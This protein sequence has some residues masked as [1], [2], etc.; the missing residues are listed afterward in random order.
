MSGEV[1][2]GHRRVGPRAL[3]ADLGLIVP[4]IVEEGRMSLTRTAKMKLSAPNRFFIGGSWTKPSSSAE[5]DVI[6]AST[7]EVMFRVAEAQEQDMDKAITAA[8]EAFDHGPW[9]RLSHAERGVFMRL[10]A[11]ALEA[12]AYDLSH[13]WSGQIGI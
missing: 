10:I 4:G 9:P 2:K 12:R 3:S 13:I 1:S 6:N 7:E 8:R 5:F 11:D